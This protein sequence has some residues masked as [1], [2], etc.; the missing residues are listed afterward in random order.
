[1]IGRTEMTRMNAIVRS[2]DVHTWGEGFMRAVIPNRTI[3]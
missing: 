1:M 3:T 2:N